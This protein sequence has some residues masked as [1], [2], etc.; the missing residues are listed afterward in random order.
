LVFIAL[1]SESI[2][3][4]NK[5]VDAVRRNPST[6]RAVDTEV[7]KAIKDWL[8]FALDRDGGRQRRAAQ[9]AARQ[10]L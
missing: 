5:C 6:C 4:V 9:K 1:N 2:V 3:D 10:S 7:E 8:R